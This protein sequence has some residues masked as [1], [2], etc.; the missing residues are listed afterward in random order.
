MTEA[1]AEIGP[2]QIG[3]EVADGGDLG[4]EPGNLAGLPD[5]HRAAHHHQGVERSEIG[6]DGPALVEFD[7]GPFDPGR[8]P[9]VAE[10]ARMLDL[11]MLENQDAQTRRL[12]DGRRGRP[13]QAASGK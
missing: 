12:I 13:V 10:R 3:G 5:I 2:A 1:D 7:R 8:A 6:G 11:D 4:R 9:E